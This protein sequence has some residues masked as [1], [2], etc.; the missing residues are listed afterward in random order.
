VYVCVC[1]RARARSLVCITRV[2]AR[3]GPRW[4]AATPATLPSPASRPPRPSPRPRVSSIR[5]EQTRPGQTEQNADGR[6]R[7]GPCASSPTLAF[8][9]PAQHRQA[10]D[11]SNRPR[12]PG[13][14]R[15]AACA[16]GGRPSPGS[17]VWRR[18]GLW[19]SES[20]VMDKDGAHQG[21]PLVHGC[22][23][24]LV[25]DRP[26]CMSR[27]SVEAHRLEPMQSR[28]SYSH[29]IVAFL[30]S[31]PLPLPQAACPPPPTHGSSSPFTSGSGFHRSSTCSVTLTRAGPDS[32]SGGAEA[33]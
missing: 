6:T 31:L 17:C 30:G 25:H 28:Q 7:V 16:S 32:S 4:A 27:L 22:L 26:W 11:L 2:P 14:G 18:V 1:V 8:I 10:A 15:A 9:P 23:Y 29:V 12:R 3:E 13:K 21:P 5:S 24:A 19:S 20:P 33:G